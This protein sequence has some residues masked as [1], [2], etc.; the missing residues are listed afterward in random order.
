VYELWIVVR[1]YVDGI[2]ETQEV[3]IVEF[4]ILFGSD[5]C[6]INEYTLVLKKKISKFFFRNIFLQTL[7]VAFLPLIKAKKVVY[8]DKH[9]KC[10]ILI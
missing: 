8:L 4:L 10:R 1:K 5:D 2:I 9:K 3:L 7:Y 6:F